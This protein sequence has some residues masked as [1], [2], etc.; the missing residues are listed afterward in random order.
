M[1]RTHC[2][3]GLLTLSLGASRTQAKESP[4]RIELVHRGEPGCTLVLPTTI[5]PAAQLA[6]LELQHH[7]R[8]I[9]GAELPVKRSGEAV[10]G[11]RILLGDSEEARSLGFASEEL[12]PQEYVVAFL[13][14]TI[15]L[16]GKDW[17]SS[18]EARKEQGYSTGGFTLQSARHKIDYW[19]AVGEPERSQGEIELPGLFDEQGTCY[20]AYDFLER[21]C[22]VRWYGP[23]PINA[24]IPKR[25]TL[26]IEGHAVRRSPV[27]KHRDACFGGGWPFMKAQLNRCSPQQ[28]QLYWRRLRLGG[29]RWAGNHTIHKKTVE[30]VFN[31]PVYQAQGPGKGS[32]LCYTHPVLIQEMAQLARDFFDGKGDLPEGQRA[33][34]D[35]FALVPDDNANWCRCE[36]CQRLLS[37]GKGRNTGFF[38]GGEVSDYWFQFVNE[39]AKELKKTHPDKYIATLAYWCYALPPADLAIEDNVSVA[40][41][42]HTC[43]Y[44]SHPEM[45]KNDRDFYEGWLENCRAPMFAWVYYHHP[46]EAA[47]I[48]KWKCFP[49]FMVHES[50]RAM[51]RFMEDGIQGIFMCGEP[52]QLEY[53][54]LMKL[55]DDP[56]L[57]VDT[58]MD[59]FFSLYFLEA[60]KPMAA[61]YREIEEIA[62]NPDN[63][64]AYYN[65][66]REQISWECLGTEKNMKRIEKWIERAEKKASADMVKERVS[67]WRE[68][69]WDWMREGRA[70][71]LAKAGKN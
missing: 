71:Y 23:H 66:P 64:P 2:L 69:I 8:A 46:M 56:S 36:R 57:D 9:T 37:K 31:H 45:T 21:F 12:A 4:A 59:E 26:V 13:Q 33:M 35:Y 39:V 68:G 22:G 51:K 18:A 1:N 20:A 42:L 48:Q 10:Q 34:G 62:S 5:T 27:L 14:D 17:S 67:M 28:A 61:F 30:T 38:S 70:Q 40:P 63:Y 7:V 53:Y 65:G 52:D 16:L 54:V 29:L 24:V 15:V 50:A 41:C 47:L 6:A 3:F 55:W 60:A 32:Q 11:T 58:L 44:A 49:N 19:T 43:Y 25:E